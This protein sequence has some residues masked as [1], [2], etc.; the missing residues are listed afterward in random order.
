MFLILL[1]NKRKGKEKERR[2]E[3]KAFQS[4]LRINI[5]YHKILSAGSYLPW[6]SEFLKSIYEMDDCYFDFTVFMEALGLC[7]NIITRKI[8][9]LY[10]LHIRFQINPIAKA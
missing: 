10:L 5:S 2:R 7:F 1:Q 9:K 8:N 4:R 6:K 3:D